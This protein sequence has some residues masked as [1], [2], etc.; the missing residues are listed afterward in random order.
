MGDGEAG[1][2][3]W[4]GG[5]EAKE[6]GGGGAGGGGYLIEV[7]VS[8]ILFN[9]FSLIILLAMCGEHMEQTHGYGG[10]TWRTEAIGLI[11]S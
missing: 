2:G 1:M 9:I 5:G 3:G 10:N 8:S 7:V 4:G 6:G 11:K